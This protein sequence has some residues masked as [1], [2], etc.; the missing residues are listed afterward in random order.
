MPSDSHLPSIFWL[1]PFSCWS[2]I[3]FHHSF[4]FPF[5]QGESSLYHPVTKRTTHLPHASYAL[6]H[7]CCVRRMPALPFSLPPQSFHQVD[8]IK[9]QD[10]R[11]QL[12]ALELFLSP[13]QNGRI[14]VSECQIFL[15]TLPFNAKVTFV[16]RCHSSFTT[17]HNSSLQLPT[18]FCSASAEQ[19]FT[20]L[21][22]LF[23]R[24][25][26]WG[27]TLWK[28]GEIQ[29][30]NAIPTNGFLT[31]YPTS[32]G[33]PVVY[34]SLGRHYTLLIYLVTL[35]FSLRIDP[36]HLFSRVSATL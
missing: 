25:C 2:R 3:G 33:I 8:K 23:I 20:N 35:V 27:Q 30:S 36:Q 18:L 15:I 19:P 1:N 17:F 21:F 9:R 5:A 32:D 13:C 6:R 4:G 10:R 16:I 7:A 31:S 12:W 34:A 24:S 29:S 28:R 26:F 22:S 11:L 14:L